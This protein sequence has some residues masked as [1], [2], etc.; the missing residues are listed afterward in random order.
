MFRNFFEFDFD[1]L[2][3]FFDFSTS[4]KVYIAIIVIFFSARSTLFRTLVSIFRKSPAELLREVIL[5]DDFSDD[6]SD[7]IELAQ[8]DK[9]TVLR[10]DKRQG[11]IRSRVRGANFAQT[12]VLT[13]L[14][15]HCEC[16]ENWLEPLLARVA[17][18]KTAVVAPI[19]DVI[20]MDTFAYVGASSD[21]KGGFEWNLV[22]KWDYLNQHERSIRQSDPTAPIRYKD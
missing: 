6:P 19:I 18:N 17:E 11:L 5:V 14:D 13:F 21:L 10:N 1:F 9:V 16:N 3:L 7:G 15:S 20:N 22:F 2:N 4:Q 12:N 8:I